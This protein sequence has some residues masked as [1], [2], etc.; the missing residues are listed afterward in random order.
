MDLSIQK[1]IPISLLIM[2]RAFMLTSSFSNSEDLLRS[3]ISSV[4]TGNEILLSFSFLSS[5]LLV[6]LLF[7]SFPLFYHLSSIVPSSPFSLLLFKNPPP[8]SYLLNLSHPPLFHPIPFLPILFLIDLRHPTLS[9]SWIPTP[10]TKWFSP[11]P[12]SVRATPWIC[13]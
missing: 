5:L 7:L 8:T 12:T 1:S 3:S 4:S 9:H 2:S 11:T 6:S 10:S 13:K